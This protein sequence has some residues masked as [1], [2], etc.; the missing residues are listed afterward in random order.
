MALTTKIARHVQEIQ[1]LVPACS[2]RRVSQPM[3]V[4]PPMRPERLANGVA[5]GRCHEIVSEIVVQPERALVGRALRDHAEIVFVFRLLD[6]GDVGLHPFLR[7]LGQRRD[8]RR[9]L[10]P[11][12]LVV[13]D[14]AAKRLVHQR[15]RHVRVEGVHD[16]ARCQ[17]IVVG[18]ELGFRPVKISAMWLRIAKEADCP[19]LVLARRSRIRGKSSGLKSTR[20]DECPRRGQA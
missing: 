12:H 16:L 18:G 1:L 3:L 10:L 13:V 2:V 8:R 6:L 15:E 14:Q 17:S 5:L 7:N 19:A 20:A 9:R 11:T 4:I